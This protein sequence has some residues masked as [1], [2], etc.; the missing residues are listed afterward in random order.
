MWLSAS[1]SLSRKHLSSSKETS[2]SLL[3]SMMPFVRASAFQPALRRVSVRSLSFPIQ[4]QRTSACVPGIAW[5][6]KLS[7]T[8]TS[9]GVVAPLPQ[10][11]EITQTTKLRTQGIASERTGVVVASHGKFQRTQVALGQEQKSHKFPLVTLQLCMDLKKWKSNAEL[12]L[13]KFSLLLLPSR[14]SLSN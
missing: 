5:T 6:A 10:E 1:C 11:K 13:W 9:H 14:A 7:V 4:N 3:E 12:G 2:F 8:L